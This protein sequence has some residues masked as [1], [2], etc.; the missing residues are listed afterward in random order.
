MRSLVA[1]LAVLALLTGCSQGGQSGASAS[2]GVG[3]I[4]NLEVGTK[5]DGSPSISWPDGMIVAKEQVEVMWPGEG[6]TLVDGQPLLLDIYIED[7]STHSVLKNTSTG[8]AESTLL[9]PEFL[10][11]ALYKA[12]LTV[13]VGARIVAVSPPKGEFEDEPPLAIVM[14][15]LPDRAMGTPLPAP[16]DL[17]RVSEGSDGRPIVTIDPQRELPRQLT[18]A[19][20]IQGDG[21]Q[22][23]D[24]SYIVAQFLAVR[25][26]DGAKDSVSWRVGDLQQS[27]WAPETAPFIGQIAQGKVVDAWSQGL[28]DQVVGS[29]VLIVA[30]EAW[31]YPGQGTLIYV[32]DILDVVTPSESG[33]PAP[34]IPSATP[35]VTPS[36]AAAA[37]GA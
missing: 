8:L 30:P 7:L 1:I 25:G 20:L 36:Q 27:T 29:R 34:E 3:D 26:Q 6:P 21:A 13:G 32:V 19:T 5:D 9:A 14:D 10:G 28:I 22:I 31:A 12:L 11:E 23:Q 16:E 2:A 4:S 15:V 37:G 24:G 35:S 17:P 33:Q 18:V